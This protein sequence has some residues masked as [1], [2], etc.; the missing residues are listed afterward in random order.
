MYSVLST[1]SNRLIRTARRIRHSHAHARPRPAAAPR[2]PRGDRLLRVACGVTTRDAR[3]WY[4]WMS[5][6]AVGSSLAE[7]FLPQQVGEP[8]IREE[9][10][11]QDEQPVDPSDTAGYG[12]NL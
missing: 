5:S 10:A 9:I 1:G 12:V 3:R 4:A 2:A 7:A 8:Q 6:E 11:V